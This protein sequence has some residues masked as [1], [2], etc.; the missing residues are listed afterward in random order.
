LTDPRLKCDAAQLVAAKE[1]IQAFLYA[2]DTQPQEKDFNY[3][4]LLRVSALLR[5]EA[6]PAKVRDD[7]IVEALDAAELLE[8]RRRN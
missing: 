4:I 2:I 5:G 3:A 7:Q 1:L 6:P 8:A